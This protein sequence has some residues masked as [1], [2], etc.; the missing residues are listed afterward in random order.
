M[1]VRLL[2][3]SLLLLLA[4][5]ETII[6]PPPAS[7]LYGLRPLPAQQD[8]GHP[9]PV[10][11]IVPRPSASPALDRE[12][13]ALHKASNQLNYFARVRWTT[14]TPELV[15]FFIIDSVQNQNLFQ[16]VTPDSRFAQDNYRLEVHIQDFQAEYVEDSETP[17][18]SLKLAFILTDMTSRKPLVSF[19]EQVHKPITENRLSLVVEG[20]QS[21]MEEITGNAI[22]QI[23][24]ALVEARKP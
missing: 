2:L 4:G 16:S 8:V 7:Q 6:S 11:L 18:V 19:V 15:R 23:L 10:N 12:F 1:S 3:T 13:I 5:C 21:G 24:L 14:T 17:L 20:F 9:L 22:R